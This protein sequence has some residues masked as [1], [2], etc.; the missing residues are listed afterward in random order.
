MSFRISSWAAAPLNTKRREPRP[1]LTAIDCGEPSPRLKP[2]G[3]MRRR[4]ATATP[5]GLGAVASARKPRVA[6]TRTRGESYVDGTKVLRASS[7]SLDS[8]LS[9]WF[10]QSR[11]GSSRRSVALRETIDMG[12][13][14]SGEGLARRHGDTEFRHDVRIGSSSTNIFQFFSV[15]PPLRVRH[16]MFLPKPTTLREEGVSLFVDRR[17]ADPL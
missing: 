10:A 11:R 2:D 9:Q 8:V 7:R 3:L 6:R 17:D 5:S 4:P 14:L 16:S 1:R 15:S 13:R 12:S